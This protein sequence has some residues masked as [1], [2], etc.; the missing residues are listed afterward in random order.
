MVVAVLEYL[1]SAP[2]MTD[3]MMTMLQFASSILEAPESARTGLFGL[4]AAA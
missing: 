1:Y 3:L 4:G 2:Q